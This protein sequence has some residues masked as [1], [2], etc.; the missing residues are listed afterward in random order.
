MLNMET[1]FLNVGGG[2]LINSAQSAFVNRII[3]TLPSSAP[4]VDPSAIVMTGATELR[5]VFPEDQVE[6]ILV[7]Y[8]AGVKLAFIIAIAAS[9]TAMIGS[10]FGGWK[11]L[12]RDAAK[13]AGA[14]A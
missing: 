5:T 8:M 6:G 11:R 3:T 9:G 13:G 4:G 2:L 1:V 10:L 14:A 7:A 12:N